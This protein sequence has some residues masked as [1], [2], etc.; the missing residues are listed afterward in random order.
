MTIKGRRT[1]K[2]GG[3]SF[4]SIAMKLT[5]LILNLVFIQSKIIQNK[6]RN[7]NKN[8]GK[9]EFTHFICFKKRKAKHKRQEARKS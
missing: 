3:I 2:L 4:F 9:I 7:K 5:I 8:R 1:I 6:N